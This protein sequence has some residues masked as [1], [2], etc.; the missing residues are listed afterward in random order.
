MAPL[1]Q[2]L[3]DKIGVIA[4]IFGITAICFST[5]F[6]I[7]NRYALAEDVKQIQQRLDYKI[8]SDQL[9]SVQDR[10]WKIE[11]RTKGQPPSDQTIKEELRQLKEDKVTIEDQLKVMEKEKK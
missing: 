4:G 3:K 5:Y 1:I 9:R 8:K 6:Y 10:I 7:E 2:T 11:D